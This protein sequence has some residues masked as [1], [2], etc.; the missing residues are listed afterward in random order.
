SSTLANQN[1]LS[2]QHFV[3]YVFLSNKGIQ[4]RYKILT[5]H[6]PV[7]YREIEKSNQIRFQLLVFGSGSAACETMG[8]ILFF[9]DGIMASKGNNE[10]YLVFHN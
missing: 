9:I 1:F 10:F 5:Y 7:M 3:R 6:N 4:H 8:F 2:T